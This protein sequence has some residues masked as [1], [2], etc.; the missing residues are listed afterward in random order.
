MTTSTTIDM[1]DEFMYSR[2]EQ[3]LKQLALTRAHSL[4]IIGQNVNT[5]WNNPIQVCIAYSNIPPCYAHHP[6]PIAMVVSGSV[7]NCV[8]TYFNTSPCYAYHSSVAMV[9]FEIVYSYIYIPFGFEQQS[10]KMHLSVP[11]LFLWRPHRALRAHNLLNLRIGENMNTLWNVESVKYKHRGFSEVYYHDKDYNVD[12]GLS[13]FL[14]IG[15][16]DGL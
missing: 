3:Q 14:L 5:L 9:V 8:I 10:S 6:L 7:I 16:F 4:L 2:T 12:S 1:V 15:S 11:A 13:W